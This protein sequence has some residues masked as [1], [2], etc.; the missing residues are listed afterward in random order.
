M[1]RAAQLL[2]LAGLM[3]AIDVAMRL[4]ESADPDPQSLREDLQEAEALEFYEKDGQKM[5]KVKIGKVNIINRN[6][7]YYSREVYATAN[8]R[9]KEDLAAGRLWGLLGH[10]DWDEPSKGKPENIVLKFESLDIEGDTV[11]GRAVVVETTAGKELAA[12][13]AAKVQM[14][15]S[16][17]GRGTISFLPAKEVDPSWPDP[18]EIIG[19]VNEDYRYLT[20]DVV[21]DPSNLGGV[22]ESQKH[23]PKDTQGDQ[24]FKTLEELKAKNPELYA[25]LLAEAK[26]NIA[27]LEAKVIELTNEVNTLKQEKVEG[28]RKAMVAAQLADAK[29]P[30]APKI[31]GMDLDARFRESLEA[32]ALAAENDAAAKA[33]VLSAITERRALLGATKPADGVKLPEGNNGGGDGK[34]KQQPKDNPANSAVRRLGLS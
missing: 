13:R 5:A 3:P 11:V 23:P 4:Q 28:A 21:T 15:I 27:A 10:P 8:E 14:G 32:I 20:I 16:T 1:N 17:N 24:M 9:A 34:D 18:E 31:E 30:A 6:R 26:G 29:L 7:R 12:L 33:A 25:A 2:T 22:L 19:V